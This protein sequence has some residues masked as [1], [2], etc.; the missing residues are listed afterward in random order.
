MAM[1][2]VTI[3]Q[4]FF[5]SSVMIAHFGRNP[6]RGGRPPSD[7]KISRIVNRVEGV[8]FH[9]RE[10]EFIVVELFIIRVKNIGIVR[11]I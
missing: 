6:V 11:I 1:S 3:R 4:L 8:L 2:V 7:S 9:V 5:S 10:I